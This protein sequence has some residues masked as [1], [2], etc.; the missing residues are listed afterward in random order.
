MI[1]SRLGMAD[2]A[3]LITQSSE[4][5]QSAWQRL[6]T[7]TCTNL[8]SALFVTFTVTSVFL[9][10]LRQ[11]CRWINRNMSELLHNL[12]KQAPYSAAV[13]AMAQLYTD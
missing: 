12:Q 5:E 6:R 2:K 7:K 9:W 4:V 3:L 8:P 10:P 1:S 13:I 11:Y